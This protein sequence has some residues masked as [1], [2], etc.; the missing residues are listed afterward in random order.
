MT[1]FASTAERFVEWVG[2]DAVFGAKSFGVGVGICVQ[3]RARV[4]L[5]V[6]HPARRARRRREP[7][8][9]KADVPRPPRAALFLQLKTAAQ[10]PLIVFVAYWLGCRAAFLVGT[11]SD[12]IFAPFWPPN[13]VLLCA[14]LLT[15]RQR[16]WLCLLAA[17]PAHVAAELEIGMGTPQ[18]LVAFATNCAV[19]L[20]G[21]AAL[22]KYVGGPPWFDSLRKVSLY[23]LITTVTAPAFVALGGA[24]VPILG[25]GPVENYWRYWLDWYASNALGSVTLGPVVLIALTE[26]QRQA[27]RVTRRHL[28]AAMLGLALVAVC[29]FAF[30]MSTATVSVGFLPA[31]LYLPVPLIVWAAV[32]FGAK[33]ASAAILAVT[34]VLIWSTLNNPGPF[35]AADPETNVLAIQVFLVGLAVP[36]LLLGAAIEQIRRAEQRTRESEERMSFAAVSANV[37]L[38]HL[39]RAAD[40]VWMTQHGRQMLGFG[41]S[42]AVTRHALLNTIHPEDRQAALESLRSAATAGQLVDTEFRIVRPD[43]DV[44]WVRAR[45]RKHNN[46]LGEEVEISGTFAD[47]TERKAAENEVALQ[48]RELTH[49]MRVSMLGELSGGIAHEL[50]QPLTAILSNAQAARLLLAKDAPNLAE[51]A[52]VLDDIIQEDNRAGEVIH[53]LRGLLKKGEVKFEFVDLNELVRSTLRLLHSELISRGIQV[54]IE[55]AENLPRVSGDAVQLQQVLLNLIMNAMDAMNEVAAPRRQLTLASRTLDNGEV[56]VSVAD[57]G[58]GLDPSKL[59]NAFQPF[60]TTKERGLGLGLSI[61]SSIINSHGGTMHLVNNT[62]S[63]AT[64]TFRLPAQKI[65]A[66]QSASLT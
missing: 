40:R 32:R 42:E 34:V 2:F 9:M 61:C 38:W 17:F 56:E 48:R 41:P 50:T 12:K 30:A 20:L 21:A 54:N 3:M 35:A 8:A 26:T 19:A 1:R 51:M 16:W 37:G 23:V 46:E 31:L 24:F 66:P 58:L 10:M 57:R 27:F 7:A 13:I 39:Y 53:R 28:E 65:M 49:L 14:L 36:T 5:P 45:A 33:G 62:G 52:D 6:A 11:L 44:R 22:Q 4:V 18:L 60:F 64:A 25:G 15:P 55:L 29:I 47:V 63:G 43:G 59:E